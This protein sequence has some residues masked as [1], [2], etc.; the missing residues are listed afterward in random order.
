MRLNL[1]DTYSY[2]CT[3]ECFMDA[4]PRHR[5]THSYLEKTSDNRT[6]TLQEL[7]DCLSLPFFDGDSFLSETPLAITRVK[8]WIKVGSSKSYTPTDSDVGT[9]LRLKC[10]AVHAVTGIQLTS[11]KDVTTHAVIRAP[12]APPRTVI[13]V[14]LDNNPGDTLVP[15]RNFKVLSYNILAD[16]YAITDRFDYCP[17]WAILWPY[18][19]KNLLQEIIGYD[20]D[21]ICLQ[22]VLVSG[23]EIVFCQNFRFIQAS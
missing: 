14:S 23:S 3:S 4:W 22:E 15:K 5:D 10:T 13:D 17:S 21:I 8:S 1:A 16:L 6:K 19:R 20:A 18:R 9:Y 12:I 11:E 2:H 7:K